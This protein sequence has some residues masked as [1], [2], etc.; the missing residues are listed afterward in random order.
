MIGMNDLPADLWERPAMLKRVE[1]VSMSWRPYAH[2]RSATENAQDLEGPWRSAREVGE[3]PDGLMYVRAGGFESSYKFT[4]AQFDRLCERQ[5]KV[6]T[7][8]LRTLDKYLWLF[9]DKFYWD[10]DMLRDDEVRVLLLARQLR[11][12]REIA[13]AKAIVAAGT[14]SQQ[15]V[16]TAIPDAIKLFVFQRDGGRC[17]ECGSNADLQFDHVIPV[18]LGGASTPENVRILC[19]PCYRA[20]GADLP[21]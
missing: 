17:V 6:P 5:K 18:S 7:L 3:D 19:G 12:P 14:L 20:K 15:P 2:W 4:A 10:T 21:V 11:A 1:V 13:H 9:Q 8:V 16:R